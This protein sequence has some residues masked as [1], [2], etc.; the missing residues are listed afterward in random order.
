MNLKFENRCC[1]RSKSRRGSA[2]LL[3]T[4][5][6]TLL[7]M[8]ALV[9]I[10]SNR[11]SIAQTHSQH[12]AVW[13]RHTAESLV[14]RSI[15][16]LRE[17][18]N[19]VTDPKSLKN[20]LRLDE[21]LFPKKTFSDKYNREGEHQEKY[22]RDA[23]GVIEANSVKDPNGTIQT[24]VTL[25]AYLYQPNNGDFRKVVPGAQRT[26]LLDSLIGQTK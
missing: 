21:S 8:S 2:L 24:N 14:Q 6:A 3:C 16:Q 12:A 10:R 9:I 22:F 20:V 11:I 13:G 15:A 23:I 1:K 19:Y 26:V 25:S 18:P 4:L 5:A 17:D 7:S